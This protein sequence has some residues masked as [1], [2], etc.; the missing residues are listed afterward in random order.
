MPRQI[1]ADFQKLICSIVS[2]V[3]V[4]TLSAPVHANQNDASKF[5]QAVQK[6]VLGEC[7][8]GKFRENGYRTYQDCRSDN[9]PPKCKALVYLDIAAWALCVRSCTNAST[10]SKTFGE[11]SY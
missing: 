4:T 10:Y 5:Y 7:S 9:S 2:I 11:C 8:S 3:L 1:K 6:M